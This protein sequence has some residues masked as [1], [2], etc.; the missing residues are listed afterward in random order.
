MFRFSICIQPGMDAS[1]KNLGP[2]CALG[3]GVHPE[4]SEFENLIQYGTLPEIRPMEGNDNGSQLSTS[5]IP[6]QQKKALAGHRLY[7]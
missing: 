2:V 4:K 1:W 6:L 5:S 3:W 7:T